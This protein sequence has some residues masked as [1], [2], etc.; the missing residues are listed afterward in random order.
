MFKQA[1]FEDEIYRAMEKTLVKNQTENL[2]G[3]DKLAKATDLLN[4]AASIFESAEM[5]SEA[6]DVTEVLRSLVKAIK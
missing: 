6:N 2:H 3:F 4:T 1:S 5:Y